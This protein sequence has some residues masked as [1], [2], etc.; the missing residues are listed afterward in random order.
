MTYCIFLI[1]WGDLL[2]SVRLERAFRVDNCCFFNLLVFLRYFSPNIID[3][4]HIFMGETVLGEIDIDTIHRKYFICLLQHFSPVFLRQ[5]VA[6]FVDVWSERVLVDFVFRYFL[7]WITGK[8]I[9]IQGLKELMYPFTLLL[10]DGL[11]LLVALVDHFK[12][13]NSNDCKQ[14]HS[15]VG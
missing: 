9:A 8:P 10:S 3:H 13:V 4:K 12:V 11:G 14:K 5:I 15:Q 6:F 2:V 1:P 7:E